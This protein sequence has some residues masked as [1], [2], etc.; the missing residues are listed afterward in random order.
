MEKTSERSKY[1]LYEKIDNDA[2]LVGSN[3]VVNKIM[4]PLNNEE[5]EALHAS[6]NK[7]KE[8]IKSLNIN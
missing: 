3:G 2:A 6:A 5:E 7:L 4:L 8:I 1:I